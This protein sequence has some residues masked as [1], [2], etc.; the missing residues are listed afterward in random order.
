MA[1]G[2]ISEDYQRLAADWFAKANKL[3]ECDLRDRYLRIAT[4]YEKLAALERKPITSP[5][6][7]GRES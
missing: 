3:P 4:G 7:A 6:T 2:R 5:R 1:N